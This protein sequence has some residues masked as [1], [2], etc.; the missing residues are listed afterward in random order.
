MK[1]GVF[2]RLK[3][4][5]GKEFEERF[6][7]FRILCLPSLLRQT[8]QNFEIVILCNPS[9]KERIKDLSDKIKTIHFDVPISGDP[10]YQRRGEKNSV[11]PFSYPVEYDV[12]TRLDSDDIVSPDFV[13]KIHKTFTG[14]LEMIGF[15]PIKFHLPTLKLYYNYMKPETSMCISLCNSSK[16]FFIYQSGHR[17]IHRWVQEKGGK[18]TVAKFGYFYQTIHNGNASTKIQPTDVMV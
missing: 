5:D 12:Q 16:D 1:H 15:K 13:K 17:S 7:M 18:V 4:N 11:M 9:H 14:D 3:Y 2:I 8:D 6:A 10:D